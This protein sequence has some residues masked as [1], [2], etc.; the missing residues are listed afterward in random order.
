MQVRYRKMASGWLMA[1]L[2]AI[3]F[4][5]TKTISIGVDTELLVAGIAAAACVGIAILWVVELLVHHRLL[6]SHFIEGLILEQQQPWLPQV[7][8]TMMATP[9]GEG[10]L[11]RVLGFYLAPVVVLIF[12]GGGAPSLWIPYESWWALVCPS[13]TMALAGLAGLAIHGKTGNT[14]E[15]EEMPE[16]TSVVKAEERE[17]W[18]PSACVVGSESHKRNRER[19]RRTFRSR[20]RKAVLR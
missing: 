2:A 15:V 14:A 11:I 7:C 18:P 5:L 9:N 10:V 1:T 6:D 20:S 16:A 17:L 4:I 19:S 3:G 12:I 8:H 13:L